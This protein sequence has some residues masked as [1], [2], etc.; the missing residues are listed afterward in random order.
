MKRHKIKLFIAKYS[1]II[2]SIACL[3]LSVLIVALCVKSNII[4]KLKNLSD[5]LIAVIGTLLGAVIG[6]IFTLL[7]SI[8]VNQKQLKAQTHIKKKNLIYKP[9][10]DEL[11]KIENLLEKNPYPRRIVY[12]N[13]Y[14]FNY[15]EYT[16]WQRIK[17]DTRYLETPSTLKVEMN[18]LYTTIEDYNK[19]MEQIGK[20]CTDIFNKV[21]E[22]KIGTT[23]TII[24]IG[25]V[26]YKKVLSEVRDG[27]FYEYKDSLKDKVDVNESV[28]QEIE[29]DFYVKCQENEIIKNIK[30]IKNNWKNQQQKCIE[31]LKYMIMSVNIKYEG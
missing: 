8:Y 17:S 26:L 29:N 25:D 2:I 15:P 18:K 22:E 6:G 11:C 30:I 9:L 10:Y 19:N 7:G 21:L 12:D 23:C 1:K 14:G 31:L 24:N 4:A 28:K 20:I 27:L 3:V 13:D 5:T 16:V